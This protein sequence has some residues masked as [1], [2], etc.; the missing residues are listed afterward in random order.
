MTRYSA[1][2]REQAAVLCS[3]MAC[4][5]VELSWWVPA[6]DA[7]K[8]ARRLVVAAMN[9]AFLQHGCASPRELWA[10]ADAMLRTGW[11]P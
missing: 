10:E 9:H 11:G 7:P 6:D 4:S 2:T 5:D 3:I 1:R 8:A